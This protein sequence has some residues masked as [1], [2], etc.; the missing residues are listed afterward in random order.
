MLSAQPKSPK[1]KAGPGLKIQQQWYF[2][3]I[4]VLS[5]CLAFG[6]ASGQ[7]LLAAFTPPLVN[8]TAARWQLVQSSIKLCVPSQ[9]DMKSLQPLDSQAATTFPAYGPIT[10]M[11]STYYQSTSGAQ[12]VSPLLGL[13]L[14]YGPSPWSAATHTDTAMFFS[15]PSWGGLPFVTSLSLSSPN[16]YVQSIR[17]CCSQQG[18]LSA[19][20]IT[21]S[22]GSVLSVGQTA[23]CVVDGGTDTPQ[24][25]AG[26]SAMLAGLAGA[27][28]DGEGLTQVSFTWAVAVPGKQGTD[29]VVG[30][31][32]C[33][34]SV[35]GGVGMH[36]CMHAAQDISSMRVGLCVPR[37]R[38]APS[39]P[40][41]CV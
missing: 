21:T 7:L 35:H 26:S 28:V 29:D 34:P 13:L 2:G 23:K 5:A 9:S 31:S 39:P 16:Y 25:A 20:Y 40:R 33:C 10:G 24:T 36:A 37:R 19:L 30:H 38:G 8:T 6:S 4:S 3:L 18:F 22:S 27:T 11:K 14:T 1:A 15:Q 17:A 12:R 41:L 32:P